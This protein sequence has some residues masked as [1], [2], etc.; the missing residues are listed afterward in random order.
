MVQLYNPVGVGAALFSFVT[1]ILGFAAAGVI[2]TL[3]LET[4]GVDYCEYFIWTSN[5]AVSGVLG[6]VFLFHSSIHGMIAITENT[7][8]PLII[9]AGIAAISALVLIIAAGALTGQ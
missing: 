1:A 3:Y 5:A 7:S 9:T 8:K 6:F 4:C 2:S